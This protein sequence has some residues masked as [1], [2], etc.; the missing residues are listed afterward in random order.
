[1][2][3][4]DHIEVID[5]TK[6]VYVKDDYGIYILYDCAISDMADIEEELLKMGS[7]YISKYE[8][9][10]DV[11]AEKPYPIVD[12]LGMVEDMLAYEHEFQFE[13][14]KLVQE[15]MECYEHICDPLE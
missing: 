1:M 15:Y 11:E 2:G 3:R 8:A 5:A 4:V 12:R 13:K 6:E 14:V 7:F 9:L 10:V